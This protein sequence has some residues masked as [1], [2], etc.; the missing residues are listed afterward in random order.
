VRPDGSVDEA[1]TAGARA[2]STN[3]L[4]VLGDSLYATLSFDLRSPIVRIPLGD[5]TGLETA[6][7]LSLGPAALFWKGLDDGTVGADGRLYVTAHTTGEVLRVDLEEGEACAVTSGLPAPSSARFA[8]AFGD[9]DP[10]RDL[11]V[12]DLTGHVFVVHLQGK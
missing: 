9:F 11:F 4:N 6:V 7:E 1:W 12:T 8:Q 2:F 10:Q 5:P 3:G